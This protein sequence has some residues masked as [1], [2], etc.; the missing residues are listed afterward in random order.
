M[1]TIPAYCSLLVIFDDRNHNHE[2]IEQKIQE[3]ADQISLGLSPKGTLWKIPVCY[4]APYGYDLMGLA[5]KKK[6]SVSKV[7]ALHSGVTYTLHFIGFLPGFPYLSVLSE[8]LHTPR[9]VM[10]DL[11]IPAGSVAIGGTQTGIYPSD[12]PG[13]W[14]VIGNTPISLFNVKKKP[15]CFFKAGDKIQFV[16]IK[17]SEYQHIKKDIA[18]GSHVIEREQM[19]EHD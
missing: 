11:Q 8:V 16:P 9:K 10:P 5:E 14:H 18:E 1:E 4:E 19:D 17:G 2:E 6:L 15:P 7:I 13:G 12:S 3:C